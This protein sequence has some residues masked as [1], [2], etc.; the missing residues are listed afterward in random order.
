MILYLDTSA[1]VKKYF[2]ESGSAAVIDAWKSAALIGTSAITYAETVASLYRKK[3]EAPISDRIFSAAM[4]S[5]HTD[6]ES[7]LRVEVA[8]ELNERILSLVKAHPLRG[9]DAIHLA[10]ALIVAEQV[11]DR[12]VFACYDK[13]LSSAAR[14]EGLEVL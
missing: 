10:S 2:K 9:F 5:F 6:W 7:F 11:P 4:K 13:Q 12:V 3:R 1:C 14:E 8:R